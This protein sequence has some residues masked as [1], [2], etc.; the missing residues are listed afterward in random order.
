MNPRALTSE[1][2]VIVL[3]LLGVA[4]VFLYNFLYR[5][6]ARQARRLT[7][8]Q[9]RILWVL[10]SV[11]ALLVIVA[12]IRPAMTVV[13]T[14]KRLPVVAFVVDESLSMGFPDSRDNPIV[15]ANPRDERTRYDTVKSV[16]DS[17]QTPLRK[18]HRCPVYTFS[19]TLQL[20]RELPQSDSAKD[21]MGKAE[22]FENA[23]K[24]TGEYTNVGDALQDMLRNLSEDKISGVILLS[25]GRQ[26]GGVSIEKATEDVQRAKVPVHSVALGTEHPLRDLRIDDVIVDPE[27]SL[28]DVLL[29]DVTVYNQVQDS[30]KTTLTLF[31][32]GEEVA[33]KEI[34]L[35]RGENRVSQAVIPEV[36]GM[37][38]FRLKLP[39][40][41]DEV[42]TDNNEAVVHVNIVKRTLR[43]LLISSAP[44]REYFYMVP[45][46]LRDPVVELSCWLQNADV[47][48]VHQGNVN[49][50]RLPMT[51]ADWQRYDVAIL[52]DPDPNKITTQQVTGIENMV[53]KGGG[54]LVIAGRN[55]GL[56]KFVQVHAVKMRNLLPVEI[57]K[58]RLPNYFQEFTKR[59]TVERT[60]RGRGHP[61]LRASGDE[62]RNEKIWNTFPSFYWYHPVKRAKPSAVVLLQSDNAEGGR[63][64]EGGD[65]IMAI[66]RYGEG[67][68]F[69][70]GLNS[71]WRWRYP[72]ESF[73][74]D[75]FWVRAIRYLGETRL[76]GTQQQVAL[77]TDRRT[78]GPGETVQVRLRV[79]DPALMSQLS[80]VPLYASVTSPDKDEQMVSLEPARSGEMLY[81]GEYLARRVGGMAVH[82]TQAAPGADSE[83][84]PL[85]DVK[86]AFQVRM[87]SL[88]QKDTSG[89]LEGMRELA[90]S[91]GG[92]YYDYHN[93]KE[94]DSLVDEIPSE[95]QVLRKTSMVEIWD[96]TWL[97]MLFLCLVATEWSL[98]KWWGLL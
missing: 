39:T 25:D 26:T 81:T 14:Q 40:F 2:M 67:A 3:L 94:I 51:L 93:M 18:T 36:E 15:Q 63:L 1:F 4:L 35:K 88:E 21:K 78:Y 44:T 62:A 73:D 19:D 23:P 47:D 58:N 77:S 56:A 24:P 32:Q 50:E 59:T 68:V 49:I 5:V 53:R 97:L 41:P 79:L 45:A 29:F 9:K 61:I 85:F 16:I 60:P 8:R 22:L 28:G 71:L 12:L 43:V 13:R 86:H 27:G 54:L 87:Q 6:E 66:Q 57:D 72:Y 17:I 42:N 98:R 96:T 38:E 65:C 89:D 80:G 90:D 37:R 76:K 91:T 75:R 83:A 10:R 46:L 69:Y 11:A 33:K 64:A 70:C 34:Y 31:E 20:L 52:Y 95:P 84:K 48:Y 74:Y 30:L 82:C 92:K 7:Q 55:H